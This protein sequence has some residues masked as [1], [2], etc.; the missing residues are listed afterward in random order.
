M[1]EQRRGLSGN[2]TITPRWLGESRSNLQIK[3]TDNASFKICQKSIF[4]RVVIICDLY[5]RRSHMCTHACVCMRVCVHAYACTGMCVYMHVCVYVCMFACVYSMCVCM[6][7]RIVCFWI[8]YK[9]YITV[10]LIQVI[11]YCI[12]LVYYVQLILHCVILV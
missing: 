2:G 7:M 8:V 9:L 3:H 12:I 11:L 1:P 6:Q 5:W 10:T 4:T